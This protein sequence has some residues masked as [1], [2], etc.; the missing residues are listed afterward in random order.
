MI[1]FFKELLVENCSC[2]GCRNGR[3]KDLRMLRC[4]Y[5]KVIQYPMPMPIPKPIVI[6][7]KDIDV[8][9]MNFAD[10]RLLP[11]TN[12]HQPSLAVAALCVATRQKKTAARV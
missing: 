5:D 2:K 6:R 8:E 11:F 3:I 9:Y 4:V 1:Q 7:D 12:N 10:A